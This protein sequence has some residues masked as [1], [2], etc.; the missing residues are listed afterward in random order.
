MQVCVCRGGGWGE[1]RD[2]RERGGRGGREGRRYVELLAVRRK[3]LLLVFELWLCGCRYSQ[4]TSGVEVKV[5]LQLYQIDH[6]NYLL[7]FKCVSPSEAELSAP[8][9]TERHYT[10]EFFEMC[11]RIISSLAQ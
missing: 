9:S 4:H 11:A 3:L 5:D 7:D 1:G 2:G 10:M 6:K 8:S